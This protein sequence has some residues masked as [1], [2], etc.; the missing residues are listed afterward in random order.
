MHFHYPWHF[1][2]FAQFVIPDEISSFELPLVHSDVCEL[3]KSRFLEFE[4]IAHK[5]QFLVGGEFNEFLIFFV[6]G[7]EITVILLFGRGGKVPEDSVEGKLDSFV[8]VGR[9][10][11][12]GNELPFKGV[13]SYFLLKQFRWR[14]FLH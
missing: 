11:E 9:A 5:G 1:Q 13:L 14:H 8:F 2:F 4:D 7:Q 12:D 6:F 3:A 10:H